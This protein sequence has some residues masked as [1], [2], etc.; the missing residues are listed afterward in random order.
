VVA[1]MMS[2]SHVFRQLYLQS[3]E[4]ILE[5]INQICAKYQE[6]RQAD[7]TDVM[8]RVSAISAIRD[9]KVIPPF[10]ER[11]AIRWL[12]AKRIPKRKT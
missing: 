9:L 12:D 6:L 1:D 4:V 11:D 8:P 7:D 3:A 2:E 10:S 5:Q